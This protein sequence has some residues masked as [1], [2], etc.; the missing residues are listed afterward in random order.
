MAR[1]RSHCTRHRPL[2]V[3][4]PLPVGGCRLAEAL[5]L[6]R[7]SLLCRSASALLSALL[8]GGDGTT[9]A[10]TRA[11]PERPPSALRKRS[12]MVQAATRAAQSISVAVGEEFE[13]RPQVANSGTARCAAMDALCASFLVQAMC[14]RPDPTPCPIVPARCLWTM[15]TQTGWVPS[16]AAACRMRGWSTQ[17]RCVRGGAALMPTTPSIPSGFLVVFEKPNRSSFTFYKS[18]NSRISAQPVAKHA[19]TLRT[20]ESLLPRAFEARLYRTSLSRY[21]A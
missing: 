4:H 7:S 2:V 8:T 11:S 9:L 16:P 19:A 10:G 6:R 13:V 15:R 5:I 14:G 21:P 12:F 3:R 1:A 20:M 17:R 18:L